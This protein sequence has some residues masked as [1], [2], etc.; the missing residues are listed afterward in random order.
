MLS[1][2]KFHKLLPHAVLPTRGSRHSAG[3]DLF[4]AEQGEIQPSSSKL[5]STGLQICMPEGCYGRIA[6]RSGLSWAYDVEVGAGVIDSDFYGEVCIIL[7]NLGSDVFKYDQ[8]DRLAQLILEKY[9]HALPVLSITALSSEDKEDRGG[10]FG[11]TGMLNSSTNSYGE[12]QD[13]EC[14]SCG[15]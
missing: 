4:S 1:T 14:F 3:L 2:V 12:P 11:S 13:D 10:G 8:G 15:S 9:H 6:S 7:R 5:I